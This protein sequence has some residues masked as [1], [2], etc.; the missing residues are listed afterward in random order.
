[1]SIRDTRLV[2]WDNQALTAS[3]ESRSNGNMFDLEE[4]GVTDDSIS[5]ALWFNLMVGTAAG[6]MASGGYFT[7]ITS[8][9]ATFATGSFGEQSLGSIGSAVHPLST[10]QLAA[11]SM[12]SIAFPRWSLMKYLEVKWVAVSEAA[13]GLRV[14]A[15][16]GLEP[17]CPVGRLQKA[18]SGYTM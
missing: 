4:D 16:F 1:M 2:V 7:V 11:K 17:L 13:T 18:P 15:W 9:S 6:G 8:D 3:E 14:D 5:A 12:Y 10:A